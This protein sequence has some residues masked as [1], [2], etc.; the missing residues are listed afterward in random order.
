M[1]KLIEKLKIKDSQTLLKIGITVLVSVLLSLIFFFVYNMNLT[2]L[3]DFLFVISFFIFGFGYLYSNRKI[4]KIRKRTK[5]W[6]QPLSEEEKRTYQP[7]RFICYYSASINM[8]IYLII[9]GIETL[10]K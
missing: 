2:K 7:T 5:N 6:D 3:Y 9:W 8:I 4:N 1:K 10:V